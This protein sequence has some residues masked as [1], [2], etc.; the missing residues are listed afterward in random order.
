MEDEGRLFKQ[1]EKKETN[2]KCYKIHF[3][4]DHFGDIETPIDT[5]RLV[6]RLNAWLDTIFAENQLDSANPKISFLCYCIVEL[7]KN[8]LEY[9]TGGEIAVNFE[10]NKITVIV[11][12][13]ESWDGDPNND[14]LYGSPGHGL[15]RVKGFADEFIIETNGQKLMKVPGKRKLVK[16][17]DTEIKQGTKITFVKKLILI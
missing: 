8:A 12:D 13:N 9:A 15:S 11:A 6:G 17:A 10:P 16:S 14:I 3:D 5:Y 2:P 4:D 7:S 1:P